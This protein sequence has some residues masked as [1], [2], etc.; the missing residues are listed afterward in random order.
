MMKKFDMMIAQKG[1]G[2]AHAQPLK[3]QK[4]EVTTPHFVPKVNESNDSS[5]LSS[6]G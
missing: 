2:P 5:L 4:T 1:P 6:S 3:P